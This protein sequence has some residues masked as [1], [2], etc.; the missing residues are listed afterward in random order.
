MVSIN[1]N[2][3]RGFWLK[4]FAHF[5][6]KISVIFPAHIAVRKRFERLAQSSIALRVLANPADKLENSAL[7]HDQIA[8]VAHEMAGFLI[9]GDGF[10]DLS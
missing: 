2:C 5:A 8:T 6:E 7:I 9:E 3:F 4:L 1:S 10:H